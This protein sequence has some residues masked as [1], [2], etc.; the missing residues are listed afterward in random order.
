[1]HG[2]SPGVASRRGST[3]TAARR[4]RARAAGARSRRPDVLRRALIGDDCPAMDNW[5]LDLGTTHSAVARWDELSGQPRLIEL[6]AIARK[7]MGDDPLEAPRMVPSAVH[8][9]EK[10]GWLDRLGRW[11][12]PT[13]H[14]P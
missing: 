6:P 14:A 10:V 13:R 9:L 11:A 1:M 2:R 12:P 8:F 5:A 3:A 4:E 7:P